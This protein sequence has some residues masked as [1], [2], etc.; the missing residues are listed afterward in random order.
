METGQTPAQQPKK[1]F[2]DVVAAKIDSLATTGGLDL[3]HNYSVSN[4]LTAAKLILSEVTTKDGKPILEACTKASIMTSLMKMVTQG[5]NPAKMQCYFIPYGDKLNFQRSYQGSI[6]L[7]KR[8]A[9]V[10]SV[11]SNV[12]FK[13]DSYETLIDASTGVKRLTKHEQKLE[14]RNDDAILGAYA[15]VVFEDGTSELEE[16][17]IQEIM[18]SWDQGQSKGGSPAHKNFKGEMAKKTVINRALKT[19]INSSTDSGLMDEDE[20]KE[21]PTEAKGKA[22]SQKLDFDEHEELDSKPVVTNT[23]KEAVSLFEAQAAKTVVNG[24]VVATPDF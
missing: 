6:A 16:M 20:V 9:N 19:L 5:L 8:V 2:F 11:N 15:V 4:A 13:G 12:I 1:E 14:H 10:K 24:T 22:N 21:D 3:P 23:K 17:T 18:K 7:A